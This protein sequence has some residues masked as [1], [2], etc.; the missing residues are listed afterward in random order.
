VGRPGDGVGLA[1]ACRV[2]DQV[3]G[4]GRI[5]EDGLLKKP[6]CTTSWWYRGKM[7]LVTFL[8]FWSGSAIR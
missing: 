6:C 8:V 2:L 1:R 4:A 3:A 5:L 7:I